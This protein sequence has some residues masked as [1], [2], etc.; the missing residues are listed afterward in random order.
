M[1]ASAIL[2]IEKIFCVAISPVVW[3]FNFFFLFFCCKEK[4]NIRIDWEEVNI[5]LI[6]TSEEIRSKQANPFM[7]KH[8]SQLYF[9]L[10]CWN[11]IQCQEIYA[12]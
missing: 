10:E 9:S 2:E 3:C 7:S 6:E 1:R 11:E 5:F 4:E 12:N 8:H